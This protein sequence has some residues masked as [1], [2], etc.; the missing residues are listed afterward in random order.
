MNRFFQS[1]AEYMHPSKL[2]FLLIA[3]LF[4]LS[5]CSLPTTSQPQAESGEAASD[6]YLSGPDQVAPTPLP[7]RPSYAPGELIDYTAQSGDILSALAAR[8][9]TTIDQIREATP[10]NTADA[11]TLPAGLPMQ[12]PI[13][14]E[15]LWGSPYQIIPDSLFVYGPLDRDFNT[16]AFVDSQPG[17]LKDY[18]F[19]VA[20]ED[21]RGGELVQYIAQNYSISPRLLL[22]LVDYQTGAL[23]LSKFTNPNETYPLD[24]EE[25]SRRGLYLQMIWAANTLN[26]G[27]YGWRTGNITAFELTDGSLEVMDP[28]QNAASAALH[29][30]YA[31]IMASD[32]YQQAIH[33]QGFLQTY[34]SLFQY[35]PWTKD[36]VL[37]PGSLQQPEFL[38]PFAPGKP[39]TYTGGPHTGW[40]SGDPWA[41]LDF[42]PPSDSG[43][44]TPS[45]EWVTA[46]ADGVIVRTD[47]GAAVL[48]L[49]G[50]GDERT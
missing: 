42:A 14:Y 20:G 29:Y 16:V 19:Y 44:C 36:Q 23:T 8:F 41:A 22:A 21:K 46:I 7:T 15:A 28:W 48:D 10:I 47:I 39:W 50:D 35:D 12:I 18:T 24:H 33:A 5:S 11:T 9:N 31:Q 26:N 1:I 38:L 32:A 6:L 43:G 13:Y 27:Y 4:L 49:D 2:V 40:G 34:I 3:A 17:W 25:L 37:I 30:Y 45:N